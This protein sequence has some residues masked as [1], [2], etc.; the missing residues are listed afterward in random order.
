[1]L[2]IDLEDGEVTFT[3]VDEATA[4]CEEEFGY[5]GLTW[6]AIKRNCNLNQ[7]CEFLRADEICAWIHP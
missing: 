4:F 3:E 1:M 5:K 6:D 7:L 2:I